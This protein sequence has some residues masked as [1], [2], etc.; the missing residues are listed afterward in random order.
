[1]CISREDRKRIIKRTKQVGSFTARFPDI[2]R[3]HQRAEEMGEGVEYYAIR[4]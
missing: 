3:V 2:P 1:M 4:R